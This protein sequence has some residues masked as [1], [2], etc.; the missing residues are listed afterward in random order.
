MTHALQQ[1]NESPT[2]PKADPNSLYLYATPVCNWAVQE[3]RKV[4]VFIDF[5]MKMIRILCMQ[6]Q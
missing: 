4:R 5:H 2:C 3:H 1:L 6:Q